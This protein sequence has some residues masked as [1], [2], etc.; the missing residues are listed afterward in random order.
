MIDIIYSINVTIGERIITVTPLLY[1]KTSDNDIKT[2]LKSSDEFQ[3]FIE[4]CSKRLS[5]ICIGLIHTIS[6]DIINDTYETIN[7]SIKD[8]ISDD[9]YNLKICQEIE[10][11]STE[12]YNKMCNTSESHVSFEKCYNNIIETHPQITKETIINCICSMSTYN[13][14]TTNDI[15]QQLIKMLYG[16]ER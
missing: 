8:V 13:N 11:Y 10:K 2:L 1:R 5:D 6:Y 12:L 4:K 9:F 15:R 3:A 16:K 7:F 14:E